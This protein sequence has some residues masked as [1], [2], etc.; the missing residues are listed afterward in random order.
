[1]SEWQNGIIPHSN[2]SIA[3]PI[4]NSKCQKCRAF[5]LHFEKQDCTGSRGITPLLPQ[6]NCHVP[7]GCSFSFNPQAFTGCGRMWLVI[8]FTATLDPSRHSSATNDWQTWMKWVPAWRGRRLVDQGF[9]HP[10]LAQI[11]NSGSKQRWR[12]CGGSSRVA[13][14]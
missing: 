3:R 11:A 8:D 12:N 9:W 5:Q 13:F 1:M 4:G 6:P 10:N 7:H 2:S 14:H